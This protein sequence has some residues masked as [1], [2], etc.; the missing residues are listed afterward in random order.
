MIDWSKVSEWFSSDASPGWIFGAISTTALIIGAIYNFKKRKTPN[1]VICKD[2]DKFSLLKISRSV[3]KNIEVKYKKVTIQNLSRVEIE[4]Y[5]NGTETIKDL[6]IQVIFSEKTKVLDVV[7]DRTSD[8][9]DK[10]I[11]TENI[12]KFEI[13]HLNSYRDHK[14]K[15][16]VSIV[17]DGEIDNYSVQGG[18]DGWSLKHK[19]MADGKKRIRYVVS[20]LFLEPIMFFV[21]RWLFSFN[22]ELFALNFSASSVFDFTFLIL[23]M[24]TYF[25][26]GLWVLF[27]RHKAIQD[28]YMLINHVLFH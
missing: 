15:V 9:I 16:T 3:R 6:I 18:G 1:V 10:K 25:G 27:S 7:T 22:N 17:C 13:P 21:L 8:V 14:S 5:N 23:F 12:I 26:G 24:L 19:K 28:F 4:F 2:V 11:T 20:L